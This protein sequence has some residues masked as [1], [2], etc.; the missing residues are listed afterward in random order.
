[1]PRRSDAIEQKL[2]DLGKRE[3]SAEALKKESA[4]LTRLAHINQVVGEMTRS[5][6]PARPFLGRGKK[7]WEQDV[8]A[9][10]KAS[11]DLL[12]AVK[13]SDPR[14]VKAAVSRINAACNSCHGDSRD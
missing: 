6:A 11:Q 9:L 1:V 4:D 3:L 10:K 13:A 12:K 14:A 2:I 7:E 5:Y 8:T